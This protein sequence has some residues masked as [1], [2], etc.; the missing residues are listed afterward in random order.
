MGDK[1]KK[2]KK[3]RMDVKEHVF[4]VLLHGIFL[5]I[6]FSFDFSNSVAKQ[7][8][9][10][11]VCQER[12]W[13]IY[14]ISIFKVVFVLFRFSFLLLG[15][16]V[17]IFVMSILF[18][19]LFLVF[20]NVENRA[21]II[22]TRLKIDVN[23]QIFHSKW[24]CLIEKRNIF[25]LLFFPGMCVWAAFQHSTDVSFQFETSRFSFSQLATKFYFYYFQH[26]RNGCLYVIEPIEFSISLKRERKIEK[27]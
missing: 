4:F 9:N 3:I 2:K 14:S 12:A 7:I 26:S 21:I 25:I 6:Q 24:K 19:F 18:A 27:K 20:I 16:V 8:T 1:A 13:A 22:C 23:Q 11:M 10:E 17:V 5:G 15:F